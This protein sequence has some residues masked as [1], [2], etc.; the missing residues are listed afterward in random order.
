[1]SYAGLFTHFIGH[2]V[3]GLLKLKPGELKAV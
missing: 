3:C 1:M 2:S